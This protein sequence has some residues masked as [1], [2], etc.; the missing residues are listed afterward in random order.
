MLHAL[1]SAMSYKSYTVTTLFPPL[2]ANTSHHVQQTLPSITSTPA[3]PLHSTQ[4]AN[5]TTTT[6]TTPTQTTSSHTNKPTKPAQNSST[7]AMPTAMPTHTT[8]VHE[9]PAGPNFG[10]VSQ[11]DDSSGIKVKESQL[12]RI[13]VT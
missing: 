9:T 6:N 8:A 3:K 10:D 4:V 7:T 11:S 1:P 13:R 5:M 12:S 2:A